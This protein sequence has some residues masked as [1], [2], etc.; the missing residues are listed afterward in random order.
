MPTLP[1]APIR[2]AQVQPEATSSGVCTSVTIHSPAPIRVA[3]WRA[4]AAMAERLRSAARS[5]P[6]RMARKGTIRRKGS[7]PLNSCSASCGFSSPGASCCIQAGAKCHSSTAIRVEPSRRRVRAA[8]EKRR[9]AFNPPVTFCSS[10][11]GRKAAETLPSATR[12]RN[13]DGIFSAARRASEVGPAPS[14]MFSTISRPRPSSREISSAPVTDPARLLLSLVT[15]RSAAVKDTPS[16]AATLSAPRKDHG[17]RK[18]AG[19][20]DSTSPASAFS[21]LN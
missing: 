10:K 12:S 20:I 6:R 16:S 5:S 1:A 21:S 9:A 7:N 14:N 4:W 17:I 8:R 13:I 3:F 2:N 19:E 15:D 18:L 11:E